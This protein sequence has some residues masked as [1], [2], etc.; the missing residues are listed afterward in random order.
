MST[1]NH[2]DSNVSTKDSKQLWYREY[3][4]A[5]YASAFGALAYTVLLAIRFPPFSYLPAILVGGGPGIWL[6]LSY[7][8]VL[9]VGVSGFGTLSSIL[10]NIELDEGRTVNSAIMWPAFIILVIGFV[11]SCLLLAVAGADGGYSVSIADASGT[12]VEMLLRPFVYP[13]TASTLITVLGAALALYAMI[14][15]RWHQA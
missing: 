5:A 15:A 4:G 2:M 8:L 3:R 10:R 7:V 12:T 13:I 11:V 6:L 1:S 14:S 9:L